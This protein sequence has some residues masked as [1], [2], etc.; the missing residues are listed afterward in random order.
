MLFGGGQMLGTGAVL[1]EETP[2]ADEVEITDDAQPSKA[3]LAAI[4][5]HCETIRENLR[6]V[7]REDSRARVYLGRYYEIILTKFMTPLNVRLVENNLS[8]SALIE[9]QSSFAAVRGKFVN[10][11]VNYQKGLE[12]L[13]GM[14]CKAEPA[15]FYE[16]LTRVRT[17]RR[18]VAEEVA[19]LR[20]LAAG[21]LK[22][23]EGLKKK[24]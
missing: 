7:Q 10:D 4:K 16:K 1:A 24:L 14:D 19:K 12:E 13:V 23:V 8:D 5:D 21:Q 17:K 2:V 15:K 22:L 18:A 11:F 9:N 3:Q 6:V 20:N